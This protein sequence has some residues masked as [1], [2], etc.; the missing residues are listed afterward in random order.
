[1][2]RDLC[3][4]ETVKLDVLW[5]NDLL[6]D[7]TRCM[8]SDPPLSLE[9]FYELSRMLDAEA[10][11]ESNECA[12]VINT[13]V[14]NC[15]SKE[16]SDSFVG[17]EEVTVSKVSSHADSIEFSANRTNSITD[18]YSSDVAM[19]SLDDEELYE[20]SVDVEDDFSTISP[21]DFHDQRMGVHERSFPEHGSSPHLRLCRRSTAEPS[22][23]RRLRK[24]E[25]N[26]S[27]ALRYRLKKRSEQGLV[28]SEYAMLE[29]RNIELKTRLDAMT[30]E[31]SYLKS[32]IEELCP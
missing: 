8:S 17:D 21:T 13:E 6:D 7:V 12:G 15:H 4:P 32:L 1:M 9:Q 16:I 28:V 25:Q 23:S 14:D 11:L 26:K 31:I 2:Y 18:P 30:H 20:E 19:A 24:K 27:A 10:D 3:E 22:S 5:P 29:R